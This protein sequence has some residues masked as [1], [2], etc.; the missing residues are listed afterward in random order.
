MRN[1]L[2]RE[3]WRI[4]GKDP[5]GSFLWSFGISRFVTGQYVKLECPSWV[6]PHLV[7]NTTSRP[8]CEVKQPQAWLVLRSV[9]T[10][11]PQVSYSFLSQDFAPWFGEFSVG[12]DRNWQLLII[13]H[14]PLAEQANTCRYKKSDG[15]LFNT[16]HY[17]LQS[18]AHRSRNRNRIQ[19]FS[20][21]VPQDRSS[22]FAQRQNSLHESNVPP[23]R[24][25]N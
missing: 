19:K 23:G 21:F 14:V 25:F 1:F 15:D 12:N 17:T 6:R 20:T 4:F 9:M 8:I 5:S 18:S 16:V 2:V 7:E 22:S 10:R 3:I 11:E 24:T 13:L